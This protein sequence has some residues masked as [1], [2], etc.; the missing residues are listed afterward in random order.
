MRYAVSEYQ[1]IKHDSKRDV[2]GSPASQSHIVT[3]ASLVRLN[4][5]Q[6][7]DEGSAAANILDAPNRTVDIRLLKSS[8]SGAEKT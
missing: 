2:R 4:L 7:F 6:A 1:S 3:R 8:S 5:P